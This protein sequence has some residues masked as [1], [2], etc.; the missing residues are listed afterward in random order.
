MLIKSLVLDCYCGVFNIS[1]DIT[2]GHDGTLYVLMNVIQ[3]HFTGP[4]V[5]LGGVLNSPLLKGAEVGD[6]KGSGPEKKKAR[7]EEKSACRNEEPMF[8]YF[9]KIMEQGLHIG[10]ILPPK[11]L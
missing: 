11:E 7:E 2:P 10:H 1:A 9:L 3:E 4:I 6:F 8:L 5:D